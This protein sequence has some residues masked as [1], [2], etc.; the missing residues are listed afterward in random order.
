[1]K[2]L[3]TMLAGILLG[4]SVVSLAEEPVDINTATAEVLAETIDGV[5]T[6]KAEAIVRHREQHGPFTSVDE[7][8]E[9]SGIGLKILE[10][11]RAKLVAEP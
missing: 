8:V 7:L 3:T 6:H 11:S 10:R 1:M 2:L 9:V 4:L 5:G